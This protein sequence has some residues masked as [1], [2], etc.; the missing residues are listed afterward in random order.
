MKTFIVPKET[1]NL[2]EDII[3]TDLY[4]APGVNYIGALDDDDVAAG[5]LAWSA[6]PGRI[7][8]RHIA[9]YPELFRQGYATALV[10]HLLDGLTEAYSGFPIECFY[11]ENKE[12]EAIDGFFES[13]PSFFKVVDGHF[14]RVS[15]KVRKKSPSYNK[16]MSKVHKVVQFTTQLDRTKNEFY[17]Y[18]AMHHGGIVLPQDEQFFIKEL[19]LCILKDDK[20]DSCVLV[21]RPVEG[22]IEVSY[23]INRSHDPAGLFYVMG[24]AFRQMEKLYPDDDIVINSI[25]SASEK[26][27]EKLF[28]GLAE[29]FPIIHAVSFGRGALMS[30]AHND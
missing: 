7:D 29:K 9:V 15:P 6:G 5:I 28:D 22:E 8:I 12:H 27:S 14:Y 20:I 23:T 21:K 4:G 2:F 18:V 3:P 26:L 11:V 16:V 17:S 10:N 30:K 19:S 25:N 24:E 13:N 1:L